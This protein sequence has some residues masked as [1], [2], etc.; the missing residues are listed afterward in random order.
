M[1]ETF[2][3]TND[4][5]VGCDVFDHLSGI[6]EECSSLS[7]LS[8]LRKVTHILTRPA[9][10][11]IWCKRHH[12]YC[13]LQS[14]D[15]DI[16]GFPC[17]DY[18]PAGKQAGVAGPTFPVLL[19]LISWHRQRKTKLVFLENVPEFPVMILTQLAGDMYEI[20]PFYL[21]PADVGCEQLSRMRVFILMILRGWTD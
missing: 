10:P 4:E 11:Y 18:S 3:C 13:N 16:S 5:H 20:H 8:V 12:Q 6:E 2:C 21:E 14:T 9:L 19:A 7:Q 17:T 1:L 15:I